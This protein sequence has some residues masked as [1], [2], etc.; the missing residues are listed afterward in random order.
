MYPLYHQPISI[1][2]CDTFAIFQ[3]WIA[4][5]QNQNSQ[6]FYCQTCVG[7]KAPTSPRNGVFP[8]SNQKPCSLSQTLHVWY[9]YLASPKTIFGTTEVKENPFRVTQKPSLN[10]SWTPRVYIAPETIPRFSLME[11]LTDQHRPKFAT[12]LQ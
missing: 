11:R 10:W 6:S 3:L 2:V 8:S 4:L 5:A 12:I 1:I 7:R 9:V